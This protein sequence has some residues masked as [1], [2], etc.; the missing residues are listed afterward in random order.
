MASEE[1]V[2][3]LTSAINAV[4]NVLQSQA[5]NDCELRRHLRVIGAA[6]L[7]I[8]GDGGVDDSNDTFAVDAASGSDSQPDEGEPKSV[9]PVAAAGPV[10]ETTLT[11]SEPAPALPLATADD[12]Q[13]LV[14]HF[15]GKLSVPEESAL[16]PPNMPLVDSDD[17][18]SLLAELSDCFW[19]KVAHIRQALEPST[20]AILE[21]HPCAQWIDAKLKQS[22]LGRRVDWEALAGSCE[23]AAVVADTLSEIVNLPALKKYLLEGLE[24]AAEAQSAVTAAVQRLRK[25]PDP[26]Q[27]RF[28]QWLRQRA[29]ADQKYLPRYMR[30]DD[31]ADPDQWQE[32]LI[33]VKEWRETLDDEIFRRRHERKLFGKLRY[34]LGRVAD[35]EAEQWPRAVQTIIALVD[36]GVPPSHRTLRQLLL[37]FRD[38][39]DAVRTEARQLEWV[40][41]ELA[42][43]TMPPSE[44]EPPAT[45]ER[46]E[47]LVEQVA[48]LLR[49]T[50][51]VLIGGDERPLVRQTIEEAFDLRELI[52]CDTRPHQSHLAVEP[53]IARA[54]VSVVLLAIRW[55]SHGLAAVRDFCERYNKPFVR[56]P[57]GY[58]V[59]QIA[60]QVWQQASDRLRAAPDN[61]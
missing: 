12:L 31:L 5:R 28:F 61:S 50:S 47:K 40:A 26:A 8:A 45:S 27:E 34:Q 59:N 48:D 16:K 10:A 6:L 54:E 30:R 15:A 46:D 14:D 4:I 18:P 33:R 53:F 57:G 44:P 29:T 22:V 49:N 25:K 11:L 51:V 42:R 41:R 35:G 36:L 37:P 23:V 9:Q 58:S 39:V 32:R 20:P 24:L 1:P 38:Q 56:L 13:R 55:A 21:P 52:W 7:R 2:T 3:E 43:A 17:E 60:Y 19:V